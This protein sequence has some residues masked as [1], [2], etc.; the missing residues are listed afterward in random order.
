M[1]VLCWT[2]GKVAMFMAC[3]S[4]I[5]KVWFE[6]VVSMVFMASVLSVGVDGSC[7]VPGYSAPPRSPGHVRFTWLQ[8][9]SGTGSTHQLLV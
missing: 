6:L 7:G 1:K 5:V 2:P 9:Q 3:Y 8:D 4:L